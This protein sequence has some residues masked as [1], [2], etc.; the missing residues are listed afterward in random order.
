MVLLVINIEN[1]RLKPWKICISAT[2]TR[3]ETANA[4]RSRGRPTRRASLSFA[5]DGARTPCP[6]R[7]NIV[8]V[9]GTIR[10]RPPLP[11]PPQSTTVVNEPLDL[12]RLSLDERITIKLRGDRDVRG[13]LHV[14]RRGRE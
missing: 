8:C 10:P 1:T 11:F 5:R 4:F 3:D 14:R 6:T 13:R 9:H 12:V 7:S 2:H